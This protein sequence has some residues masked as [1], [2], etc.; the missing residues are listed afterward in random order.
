MED[1][2]NLVGHFLKQQGY[3]DTFEQL[4]KDYGRA[5]KPQVLP[6]THEDL[7]TIVNDKLEYD[8]LNNN[9][10]LFSL[11]RNDHIKHTPELMNIIELQM[12]NWS[13]PYPNKPKLLLELLN[14]PL[15]CTRNE[16]VNHLYITTTK[17]ELIVYDLDKNLQFIY[18]LKSIIKKIVFLNQN[19]VIM[20]SIDGKFISANVSQDDISYVNQIQVHKRLIIDVKS[21]VIDNIHY[22]VSIGWDNMVKIYKI[23][24]NGNKN[25]EYFEFCQQYELNNT[26]ASFDITYYQNQ[27]FIIIGKN[28]I[29]L[30]DVL[31]FNLKISN[32]TLEYQISINDAEFSSIGFSPRYITIQNN[33]NQTIPLIAIATSHEP[34]MRV[35]ITSL[36]QYDSQILNEN[37]FKIYRLQILKNLNS[38]NPQ[39]SLSKPFINWRVAKNHKSQGIWVMSDDGYVR[40]IDLINHEV[41]KLNYHKGSLKEC[42]TYDNEGEVLITCGSDKKVVIWQNNK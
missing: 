28:N 10:T 14:N 13:I 2:H 33:G 4:E 29:T 42:L 12:I 9:L 8:Q 15:S 37:Q 32:L 36:N 41:E 35:I 1:I 7:V 25:D 34:E 5:I 18:K 22:I 38:E 16:Y 17:S 40:I 23:N 31:I 6:F 30:L 27:I 26:C 3:Q 11:D 39:N 20:I 19:Q 21:V 24:N